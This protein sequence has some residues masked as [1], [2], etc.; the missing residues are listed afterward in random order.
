[1]PHKILNGERR[2]S[3]IIETMEKKKSRILFLLIILLAAF[4]RLAHLR[5]VPPGLYW[6]EAINGN[7][8]QTALRTGEFK[9]FYP[10]NN[11]REGLFVNIQAGFLKWFHVHEP[12]VLRLPSALFGI[13]TVAGLYLLARELFSERVALLSAFLLATSFWHVLFSRIAFRAIMAPFFLTWS[14]YFLFAGFRKEGEQKK[15]PHI[16]LYAAFAGAMYG[17]GF[18]SYTP[19]QITPLLVIPLVLFLLRR[20][21]NR[22]SPR[23]RSLALVVTFLLLTLI[24]SAPL[25]YFAMEHS[26]I[27]FQRS[28]EVSFFHSSA[29]LREL[30]LNSLKTAAMFNFRGDQL[31]RHNYSGR[32]EVFWPVGILLVV[33][34]WGGVTVLVKTLRGR[35]PDQ[36]REG[37]GYVF[38]L[39]WLF[40]AAVPVMMSYGGIPH[41][42]RSILMIPP[43]FVLAAAGGVWIYD[44]STRRVRGSW[45]SIATVL[46]LCSLAFE[47]YHTYFVLWAKNPQ[48]SDAFNAEW[49]ELARNL[50]RSTSSSSRW[51]VLSPVGVFVNGLPMHAQSIMFITDTLR[52]EDQEVKNIHYRLGEEGRDLAPGEVLKLMTGHAP[53]ARLDSGG[54]KAPANTPPRP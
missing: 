17:L 30:V 46:L 36:I 47:A 13:L 32:P 27:Y 19:Y 52:P 6:D 31:W 35:A 49:V 51:I 22:K 26:A 24:T 8:A 2:F 38:I 29:P 14:L 28:G 44:A 42:L 21:S 9:V 34:V 5:T 33:G 45:V 4:L 18:H 15:L 20:S 12:W 1:V 54:E 53:G 48:V 41:A 43:T 37:P 7:N 40:L 25:V 16:L 10:E 23:K 3:C 39:A 11:G 50:N